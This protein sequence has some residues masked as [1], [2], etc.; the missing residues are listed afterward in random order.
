MNRYV[1][2]RSRDEV[3]GIISV[4]VGKE[5]EGHSVYAWRCHTPAL[6]YYHRYTSSKPRPAV[7]AI[8]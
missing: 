8:G 1:L 2:E 5:D 3:I 7:S 6:A 4:E